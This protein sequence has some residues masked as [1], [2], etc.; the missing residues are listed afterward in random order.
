MWNVVQ[1]VVHPHIIKHELKPEITKK[2]N[3]IFENQFIS[4]F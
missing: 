3:V 1:F 2:K 4:K